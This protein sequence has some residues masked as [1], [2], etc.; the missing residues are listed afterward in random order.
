MP[1]RRRRKCRHCGRL[2]EPDPRNRY[3]QRYCPQLACR[4]AS[5]T[6]SQRRWRASS[7]GR[8]YFR[9]RANVLRVQAWRKA[10][11]GY[12]RD[13]RKR[14]RALQ[15]HCPPQPQPLVPAMDKASLTLGALQDVC[16][17]QGFAI[18]G[19]IAQLTGSAL[20]E[21]IVPATHRLI[22]LGQQIQGPS[23]GRQADGRGQTPVVS[24]AVAASAGAV[25]LARSSPGSG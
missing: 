17:T 12:W 25:Q 6:A 13:P 8:D 21:N 5:K 9:G 22:L 14:S 18:Q 16:L 3:H 10:H 24:P 15:D 2:Y 11:P 4:Q 20:Q 23:K 7:K 19:L 1:R